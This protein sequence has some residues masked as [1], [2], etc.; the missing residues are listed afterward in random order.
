MGAVS[1]MAGR[2]TR[3][4][5]PGMKRARKESAPEGSGHGVVAG[6]DGK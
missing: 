2:S 4:G 1:V 6:S 5:E 3:K